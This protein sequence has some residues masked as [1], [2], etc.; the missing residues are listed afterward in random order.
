MEEY[1]QMLLEDKINAIQ[2]KIRIDQIKSKKMM[3]TSAPGISADPRNMQATKNTLR[4]M[5]FR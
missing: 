4:S 2:Q 3:F 5:N 1:Q